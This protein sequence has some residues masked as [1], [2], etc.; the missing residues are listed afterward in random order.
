[1]PLSP[2]Y[3]AHASLDSN[4]AKAVFEIQ[5][6]LHLLAKH[7]RIRVEAW[8]RKVQEP[9]ENLVWKR[10]R[11]ACARA[12]LEMLRRGRLEAP[13]DAHPQPGALPNL[14]AWLRNIGGSPTK[15]PYKSSD[16]AA[17][18]AASASAFVSGAAFNAGA[19]PDPIMR[20]PGSG[21]GPVHGESSS[22]RELFSSPVMSISDPQVHVSNA[23]AA[24][25]SWGPSTVAGPPAISGGGGSGGAGVGHGASP[26][27]AWPT[28]AAPTPVPYFPAPHPPS[29]AAATPAFPA[30]ASADGAAQMMPAPVQMPPVSTA[31]EGGSSDRRRRLELEAELGAS[32]ER[33]L[34]LEWRL[35]RSE[36]QAQRMRQDIQEATHARNKAE[37]EKQSELKRYRKE[38]RDELNEVI[39]RYE[40]RRQQLG[41]H[42]SPGVGAL[43]TPS[44]AA[45]P[46]QTPADRSDADFLQYLER[47]NAET[48]KLQLHVQ[49]KSPLKALA[50]TPAPA[51]AHA[52]PT[53]ASR[54][55]AATPASRTRG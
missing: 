16:A 44:Y 51:A 21:A 9:T 30:P 8:L 29:T 38:H 23:N 45:E 48:A 13:F 36:E 37:T 27:G 55:F 41:G 6:R 28:T 12:L 54:R 25:V 17:A 22:Y 34:E 31:G 50:A 7:P 20:T 53:P 24:T 15:S 11:N 33:C 52:M 35:Q 43:A 2:D 18:A 10:N 3:G 40:R 39:E 32:R 1:M 47:F 49:S 5:G 46:T 19:A 14:P 26:M 4:L 42:A